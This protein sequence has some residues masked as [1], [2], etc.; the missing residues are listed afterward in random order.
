VI[1]AEVA[2]SEEDLKAVTA[3]DGKRRIYF[4]GSVNY[5][6]V[7]GNTRYTKFCYSLPPPPPGG[8]PTSGVIWEATPGYNDSD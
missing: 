7:F 6:D 4:W 3:K 5:Q 1:N 2:L 8:T